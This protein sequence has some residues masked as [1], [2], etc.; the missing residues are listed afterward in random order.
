MREPAAGMA[1]RRPASCRRSCISAS[2]VINRRDRPVCRTS[3]PNA[4]ARIVSSNVHLATKHLR[5]QSQVRS[6][7]KMGGGLCAQRG[8]VGRGA[9]ALVAELGAFQQSEQNG[10]MTNVCLG[11][12]AARRKDCFAHASAGAAFLSESR[13][14]LELPF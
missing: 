4:V 11:L 10:S 14:A 3:L 1:G 9:D 5:S 7:K 6:E 13:H 2:E 8:A 12:R